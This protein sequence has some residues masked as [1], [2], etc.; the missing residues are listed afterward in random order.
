MSNT[1]STTDVRDFSGSDGVPLPSVPEV[2]SPST[3]EGTGIVPTMTQENPEKDGV[4]THPPS[5]GNHELESKDAKSTDGVS[6]VGGD[7][8]DH[9]ISPKT[10][11][12]P[13]RYQY[14]PRDERDLQHWITKAHSCVRQG[15][16]LILTSQF[17]FT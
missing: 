17:Q 8:G 10:P 2:T 12:S 16:S 5:D 13:R 15:K 9:P 4:T 3:P 11:V 7:T 1:T 14:A 6:A